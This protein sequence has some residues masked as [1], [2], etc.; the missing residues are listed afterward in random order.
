MK[1]LMQVKNIDDKFIYVALLVNEAT[2]SAC[3]LSGSCSVKGSGKELKI[4]KSSVPEHLQ[5]LLP[6]DMV[7]VDLKYNE[8]ILSFI[9]YGIPLAG[10]IISVLI[11]YLLKM[12]DVLS[13]LIATS[14]SG[15]GFLFTRLFDKK[16]K[17]EVIDVKKYTNF[18]FNQ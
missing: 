11:G 4:A 12:N 7:V 6:G 9:L 13:F 16:Y 3:T 17:I 5:P 14:F 2:C 18:N 8:A 1:E 15:I 10:F